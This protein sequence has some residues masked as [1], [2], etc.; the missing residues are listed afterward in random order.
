MNYGPGGLGRRELGS[1]ERG[2]RWT[3]EDSEKGP[4]TSILT[5]SWRSRPL[6]IFLPWVRL[7]GRCVQQYRNTCTREGSRLIAHDNMLYYSVYV[8][9]AVVIRSRYI[10]VHTY[11]TSCV[12]L[13]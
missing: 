1:G 2:D 5:A 3:K 6:E 10:L 11:Y 8:V 7:Q 13:F 9:D 4:L 12:Y